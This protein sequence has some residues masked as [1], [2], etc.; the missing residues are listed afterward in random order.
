MASE[1]NTTVTFSEIK[2]NVIFRGTPVTA[3]TSDDIV[4]VLNEGV[5]SQRT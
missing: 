3:G 2:P 4:V 1:D 5:D